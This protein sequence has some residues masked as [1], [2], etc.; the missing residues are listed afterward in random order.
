MKKI[1]ITIA[2]YRNEGALVRTH[3]TLSELFAGPL[4]GYEHEIV[5]VDDGSDDRSLAELLQIRERDPRVNCRSASAIP[6]SRC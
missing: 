5:F 4:A 3:A 1:S 6:A 2:V